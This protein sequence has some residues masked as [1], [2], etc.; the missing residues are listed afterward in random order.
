MTPMGGEDKPV[1]TAP[2]PLSPSTRTVTCMDADLESPGQP[3]RPGPRLL[4][5]AEVV[6]Q[7]TDL[8]GWAHTGGRL[9]AR[10]EAPDVALAVALVAAAFDVAEE[11]DHHPDVDVRYTRV[12]FALGTH[13]VGGVTQLDVELA[14]RLVHAAHAVGA[15]RLPAGADVVEVGIDT[16]DVARVSAFWQAALAYR[17]RAEDD[18]TVLVDPHGRGPRLWFQ[19]TPTPG[20]PGGPRNRLHL[21]VTVADLEEAAERRAAVEAAGGRLLSDAAAPAWWVYADPD[22]NEVC[23]CTLFGREG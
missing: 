23:I 21:D 10:Y 12:R 2:R 8:P 17:R 9:H 18:P 14:H 3:P 22:G 6:E 13:S 7:L 20:A 1:P 19:E 5:H 4:S 15:T 16:A 11:M